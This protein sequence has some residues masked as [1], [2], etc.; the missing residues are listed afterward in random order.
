MWIL[1][2]QS[3]INSPSIRKLKKKKKVT[4]FLQSVSIF[5]KWK[6]GKKRT[7]T[8]NWIWRVA[9]MNCDKYVKMHIN[10]NLNWSFEYLECRC[11]TF[12]ASVIKKCLIVTE[13]SISCKCYWKGAIKDFVKITYCDV[14][15][16]FQ[17]ELR[18]HLDSDV[19]Y[20]TFAFTH[21]WA[22]DHRP[23][24]ST[25]LHSRN[26]NKRSTIKFWFWEEEENA[27]FGNSLRVF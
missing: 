7:W 8:K 25:S 22:P 13:M 20:P 19:G 4:G 6:H 26:I 23:F 3:Y 12:S 10:F 5:D 27:P 16:V 24:P 14:T 1:I 11:Y 9:C 21:V 2:Q 17:P 18:R 15:P